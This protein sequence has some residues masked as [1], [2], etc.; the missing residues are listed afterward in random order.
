MT[1]CLAHQ[2]GSGARARGAHAVLVV[3]ALLAGPAQAAPRFAVPGADAA[4]W[5]GAEVYTPQDLAWASQQPVLRVALAAAALPPYAEVDA[6]GQVNGL[7][8]DLLLALGARLGLRLAPLVLPDEAAVRQAMQEGAAD[9]QLV[10]RPSTPAQAGARLSLGTGALPLGLFALRTAKPVPMPRARVAVSDPPEASAAGGG[11]AYLFQ[12][13]PGATMLRQADPRTALQAVA[14]QSADVYLGE[15]MTALDALSRQAIPGLELRQVLPGAAGHLHFAVSTRHAA[16][17]PLL[18]KGIIAWRS[19]SLGHQAQMRAALDYA[20]NLRQPLA[21]PIEG[22]VAQGSPVMSVLVAPPEPLNL[23][24]AERQALAEHAHWRV[25]INSAAA[26]LGAADADGRSTGMASGVLQLLAQRLGVVIEPVPVDGSS[27]LEVLGSAGVDWLA[28]ATYTPAL[29]DQLV[30]SVPWLELPNVLVGRRDAPLYWGLD[31]L[32]GKRLAV[33][34][35]HPLRNDVRS[36]HPGIQWVEVASGDE[37]LGLLARGQADAAMDIKPVTQRFLASPAGLHLRVL[38]DVTEWPAQ[39]RFAASDQTRVLMPL[40]DATLSDMSAEQRTGLLWRWIAR[41][42]PAPPAQAVWAWA[43]WVLPAAMA[44][45]GLVLGAACLGLWQ[46]RAAR[47]RDLRVDSDSTQ[48]LTLAHDG[49]AHSRL[50]ATANPSAD[51]APGPLPPAPERPQMAAAGAPETRGPLQQAPVTAPGTRL[52]LASLL[53]GVA[54]ELRDGA[55]AKGIHLGWTLDHALPDEAL[56]DPDCTRQVLITLA[57][58]AIQ[59]TESGRV[60][61]RAQRDKSA[62]PNFQLVLDVRD[63]GPVLSPLD[64]Q[65]LLGAGASPLAADDVLAGPEAP[66]AASL[67]LHGCRR[68]VATLGGRIE[69]RSQPGKGNLLRVRLPLHAAQKARALRT[70]GVLLLCD[71]N[72]FARAQLALHVA[73][74]GYP[75]LET[76]TAEQALARWKAGGVRALIVDVATPGMGAAAVIK[77]VR[78]AE[79]DAAVGTALLLCAPGVPHAGLVGGA[80]VDAYLGTPVDPQSLRRTLHAV[81]GAPVAAELARTLSWRGARPPMAAG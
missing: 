49:G 75:V 26:E 35:Q 15:L 80:A 53:A 36:A 5:L 16:L 9:L 21:L 73:A 22:S 48:F 27:A 70:E 66:Q 24:A 62:H 29:A 30:F 10:S 20:K 78:D 69:F 52:V 45:L 4:A 23:K 18:N 72:P 59:R 81:L 39:Y 58:L 33:S 47:R 3:L 79:A 63:T 50:P 25:G 8:A 60:L 42:L 34:V 1:P 14:E 71:D 51:A 64:Q 19:T 13:H 43:A 57:R 46:A 17:L 41:D 11:Q 28:L 40:L 61:L 54:D 44:A 77:L 37:A 32:R 31:S 68:R 65:Q 38:G 56:L 67:G 2:W 12:F 7:Q 74:L 76:G 6:D 55:L